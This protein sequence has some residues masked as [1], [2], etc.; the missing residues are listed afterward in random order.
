MDT[1]HCESYHPDVRFKNIVALLLFY[2]LLA[3]VQ[4]VPA[5]AETGAMPVTLR[6]GRHGMVVNGRLMLLRKGGKSH[7]ASSGRYTTQE[8][9]LLVVGT[10]GRLEADTSA[11]QTASKPQPEK[12]REAPSVNSSYH[13]TGT[14]L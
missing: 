8:G 12:K 2:I 10:E 14:H 7:P 4:I 13:Q 1:L 5:R 6:D 9:K 3:T 11:S